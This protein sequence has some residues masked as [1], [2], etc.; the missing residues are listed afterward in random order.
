[1]LTMDGAF[2]MLI[3]LGLTVPE[4]SRMCASTP[5]EALG[6]HNMGSIAAGNHAD[7]VVMD[8]Q[9]RVKQTYVAGRPMC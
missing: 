1:V 3:G 9:F 5:A 2:R 8:R 6:L 7:L 4:A